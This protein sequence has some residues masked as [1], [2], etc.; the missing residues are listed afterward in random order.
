MKEMEWVPMNNMKKWDEN[1]RYLT[2]NYRLGL[3]NLVK[4][5]P[6][7]SIF[8][9]YDGHTVWPDYVMEIILPERDA[10]E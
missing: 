7:K 4:W 8:D 6:G 1:K 3:L 2:Y 10:D 5:K 9:M